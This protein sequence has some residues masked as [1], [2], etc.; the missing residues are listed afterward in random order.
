MENLDPVGYNV[1]QLHTTLSRLLAEEGLL[2]MS[3][4]RNS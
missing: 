1:D 4:L 3:R 2:K